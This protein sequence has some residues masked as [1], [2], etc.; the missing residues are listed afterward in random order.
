ML[1]VSYYAPNYARIIRQGLTSRGGGAE[2]R[3]SAGYSNKYV[4]E[5]AVD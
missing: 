2:E 3:Y 4:C 5:V 1:H